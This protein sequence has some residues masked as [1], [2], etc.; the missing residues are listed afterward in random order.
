MS[1]LSKWSFGP[2]PD[3]MSNCGEFIA[4]ADKITSFIAVAVI[5]FPSFTNSTPRA[6]LVTGSMSIFVT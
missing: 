1:R 5:V 4:P 2:I 3:N 6:V